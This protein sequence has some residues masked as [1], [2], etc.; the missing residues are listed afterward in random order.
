MERLPLPHR[1]Y[2]PYKRIHLGTPEDVILPFFVSHIYRIFYD[3]KEF[4][5]L[6]HRQDH[7]LL[8]RTVVYRC[9]F[10]Y[11]HRYYRN[12]LPGYGY[13]DLH[14]GCSGL[15]LFQLVLKCMQKNRKPHIQY[16]VSL[17]PA[18]VSIFLRCIYEPYSKY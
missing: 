3:R 16:I 7:R 10:L 13:S 5:F 12:K 15:L 2:F 8:C 17:S 18:S 4:F 14:P 11:L 6:C 9:I 1:L